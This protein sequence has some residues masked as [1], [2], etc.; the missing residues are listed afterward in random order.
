M[1]KSESKYDAFICG[2]GIAGLLTAYALGKMGRKVLVVEKNAAFNPNGADVLKPAGIEVLEQLGL[3]DSLFEHGAL[4]RDRV[5]IYYGGN[6]VSEMDYAQEHERK[7]FM[8]IPYKNV[9]NMLLEKIREIENIHILFNTELTSISFDH[10]SENISGVLL[11][12]YLTVKAKVYIAADGI[13]SKIRSMVGLPATMEKYSQQMYF[14]QFPMVDSVRF[15]NRL[16]VDKNYSLT[17]FYPVGTHSFRCVIGFSKEEGDHLFQSK[18][19]PQ[20]KKRISQFVTESDDAI[21][22]ISSLENFATFPL[23]KM[24]IDN[25]YKGNAVFLGN[26]AHSIHPITGQGMN[27]AIEDA[28]MLFP[29][30]EDFFNGFISLPE[31]FMYYQK[32]RHPINDALINYGDRLIKSFDNRELFIQRLNLNLQT[33]NRTV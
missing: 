18:D 31:A 8:L 7:Y 24:N 1:K 21:E 10:S 17:Y 20:L 23:F 6:L 3:Y 5:L 26:S 15:C 22:A 29:L 25:Y 33:S 14:A 19:V 13:M 12:E 16:Y 4:K 9:L 2:G 28:G 27:L 11:N 32:K 30:L